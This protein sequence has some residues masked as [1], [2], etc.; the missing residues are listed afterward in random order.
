M[1][2]I[3][4]SAFAKTKY[5]RRLS[6]CNAYQELSE[7]KLKRW[8]ERCNKKDSP[9]CPLTATQ[10]IKAEVIQLYPKRINIALG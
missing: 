7:N 2:V 1:E 5:K 10:G 4:F 3:A 8:C 9:S 6:I